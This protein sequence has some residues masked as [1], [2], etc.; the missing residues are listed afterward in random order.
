MAVTYLLYGITGL[1]DLAVFQRSHNKL[2][3]CDS[4]S[5]TPINDSKVRSISGR[6]LRHLSYFKRD[7]VG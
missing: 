4:G 3:V 5:Q 1:R 7:S 2:A 6:H